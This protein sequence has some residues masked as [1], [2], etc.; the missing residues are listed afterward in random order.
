MQGLQHADLQQP[1]EIW[2]HVPVEIAR[3]RFEDRHPR[4]PI[5]GELL[6]DAEWGHWQHTAEPLHISTTLHVDTTGP[7]DMDAVVT[8][9][10]QRASAATR[11]SASDGHGPTTDVTRNTPEERIHRS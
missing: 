8:W 9:I 10:R 5:H 2:C 3:R 11:S 6:T 7:V 4:H 1:L